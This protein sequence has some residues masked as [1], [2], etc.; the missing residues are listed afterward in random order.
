MPNPWDRPPIPPRGDYHEDITYTS[1]GRFI[2]QWENIEIELSHLY[3]IFVG[4]YFKPEAYDE[5][6]DRSKTLN[7]RLRT[8]E[9]VAQNYFIKH[10]DQVNEYDFAAL[11][12]KVK[13]FSERRHEIAHGIVR[14]YHHYA[15][16]TEWSDPYD[17]DTTRT[18]LVPPHYQR[19]WIDDLQLPVYV[20]T[21]VQINS[22]TEKLIELLKELNLFKHRFVSSR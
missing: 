1:V 9:E 16:M 7:Q 12:E 11:V 13:G 4:K 10:P 17:K 22:L 20:Y 15:F 8:L 2:T 5:Y 14:P 21:S 18:C 3:A 6:Y 19:D